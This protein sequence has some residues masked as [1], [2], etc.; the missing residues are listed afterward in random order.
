VV[1]EVLNKSGRQEPSLVELKKEAE[2]ILEFLEQSGAEL[3]LVF[4]DNREI[5]KL[6]AR[7]RNKNQPTDVL[8]FPSGKSLPTD[9]HLLGD[10]VISVE[11]AEIQ[12]KRRRR[13][14]GEELEALLTHGIL[15]LLGY[16][17]ERSK[18][19]AKIMRRLERKIHRTLCDK[20]TLRV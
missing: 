12:A 3:S 4:V 6:N 8:S 11:Q 1:V 9:A 19:Q 20:K 13:P 17:H 5:Q 18:A 10:V 15:H 7:Y 14:L 16:D 2:R